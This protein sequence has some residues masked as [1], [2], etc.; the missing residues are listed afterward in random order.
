MK[1]VII[2]G[3][4]P[5]GVSAALYTARAG[6]ST[7]VLDR[8]PGALAK[9]ASIENYYGLA[10]PLSGPDLHETGL[11]QLAG[12]G[13]EYRREEAV[14]LGYGPGAAPSFLVNTSGDGEPGLYEARAVILA[15][16]SARKTVNLPGAA[17]LEGR[18][19][20]YCAVCDGFFFKGKRVCVL[21][22]GAYAVHEAAYLAGLAASMVLLTG[23]ETLSAGLPD[24]VELETRPLAGLEGK[25]RL[26]RVRF[27]DGKALDMDG[28]FIALGTA[29]STDFAR[30]L[31]VLAEKNQIVTDQE[32][33][34]NVP[35]L[36]AAGDCAQGVNQVA[37]AAGQGAGAGLAAIRYVKG[38]TKA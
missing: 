25:N 38:L 5:A 12:V 11:R 36:F 9:A 10:A 1:D 3:G 14:G 17:A 7:C 35:G 16:G 27:A 22:D 32:Q 33:R 24:G 13:A 8:G 18:G 4:G 19:V 23:G 37:V 26:E 15:A 34:T 21:G 6:L 31:G 2:I 30:K 28:C 20:S 29:S